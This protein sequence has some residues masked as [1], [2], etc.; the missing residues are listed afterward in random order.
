MVNLKCFLVGINSAV[1]SMVCVI[2]RTSLAM[3]RVTFLALLL[4]VVEPRNGNKSKLRPKLT[5]VE[6]ADYSAD[7]NTKA[8]L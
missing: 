4:H 5:K 3:T 8:R 1:S 2:V 7:A 6:A